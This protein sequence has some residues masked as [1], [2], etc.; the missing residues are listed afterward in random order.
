MPR[1]LEVP[2]DDVPHNVPHKDCAPSQPQVTA[3]YRARLPREVV[4]TTLRIAHTRWVL[5]PPVDDEDE[6]EDDDEDDAAREGD[7][8]E[9]E[10]EE[11]LD[12]EEE[13]A[14]ALE[15]SARGRRLRR[16]RKRQALY[17]ARRA[18]AAAEGQ[19]RLKKLAKRLAT[20]L[21]V[22][23]PNLAQDAQASR[24]SAAAVSAERLSR[25]AARTVPR[26]VVW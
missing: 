6:E 24:L 19:K 17:E 1:Y 2:F 18:R 22:G 25:A 9:D 26:V 14:A 21:G 5:D 20:T 4:M 15:D 11:E 10:D 7:E 3:E 16:L 23:S 12:E 8:D 13:E